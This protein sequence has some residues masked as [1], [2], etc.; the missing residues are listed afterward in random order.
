M[1]TT[2]L[3]FV[4]QE[5]TE[6]ADDRI[7]QKKRLRAYM[8][9]KR[10]E[11][12]NRDVKERALIE[13]FCENFLGENHET[14]GAGMRRTF[15]VYLSRAS[16][17]PT[18]KLI[19]RLLE[20]G[21]KVCCPRKIEGK[22]GEMEAVLYGEDFTLDEYGIREPVGQAYQGDIDVAVV[23]LLAVDR[24]GNRLGYGGGY[25]DRFLTKYPTAQRVAY[26]YDFQIVREVP[27]NDTDQR[28]DKI[29]TEKQ[30]LIVENK[31]TI[32]EDI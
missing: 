4:E 22:K 18:D 29:V 24:Q 8:K 28:M 7:E 23:P 20:K 2:K 11:T 9:G 12:E 14:T 27:I 15:F 21:Q 13:N 25:Y 10:G 5:K 26:C 3:W 31:R 19:E 32:D 6:R 30:V 1:I 17:A 16:E